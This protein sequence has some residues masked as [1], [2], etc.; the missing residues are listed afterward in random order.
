MSASVSREEA[1][2]ILRVAMMNGY[3]VEQEV[4]GIVKVKYLNDEK[5]EKTLTMTEV[6]FLSLVGEMGKENVKAID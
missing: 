1:K 5:V 3:L 4:D 2:A 6:S